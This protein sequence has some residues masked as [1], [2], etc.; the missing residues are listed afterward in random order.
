MTTETTVGSNSSARLFQG[1]ETSVSPT[2]VRTVTGS[3]GM[4][5]SEAGM[6]M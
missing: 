4:S 5:P 3:D 6:L 1:G 2:D